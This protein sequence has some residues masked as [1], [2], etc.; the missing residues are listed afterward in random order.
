M[1]EI[2]SFARAEAEQV[3]PLRALAR[4]SEAHWG[5]SE[6]FLKEF[7]RTFNITEDFI[8]ANPTYAVWEGENPLAFWAMQQGE[9]DWEL[10][11]FYV[12][13]QAIGTG[14]G[15][16]MWNHLTNWCRQQGIETFHFVTSPQAVGFY[17]KMG[18][19]QD[20][21]TVSSIDGRPIP[22]FVVPAEA[23]GAEVED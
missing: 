22:H 3:Q 17:E 15:R 14:L 5:F 19:V 1:E 20:R 12:S 23:L 6:E 2:C 16:K 21:M 18:A 8:R 4:A 11:F 13:E 10:E 9:G 7:D